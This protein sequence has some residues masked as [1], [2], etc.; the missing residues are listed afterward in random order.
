MDEGVR[1]LRAAIEE[2][3][4]LA[5]DVLVIKQRVRCDT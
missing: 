4:K 2:S 1:Q 5:E 3:E